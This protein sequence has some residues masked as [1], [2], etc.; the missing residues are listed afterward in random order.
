MSSCDS[1]HGMCKL[2]IGANRVAYHAAPIAVNIFSNAQ[3]QLA[4]GGKTAK[5]YQIVANNH[6]LPALSLGSKVIV[7]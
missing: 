1:I 6:P 2:V 5:P 3:L 4:T 7:V